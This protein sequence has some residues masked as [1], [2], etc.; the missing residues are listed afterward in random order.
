MVF[1]QLEDCVKLIIW[2]VYL[3]LFIFLLISG[4]SEPNSR[5]RVDSGYSVRPDSQSAGLVAS[6]SK[7]LDTF[8]GVPVCS[9]C[10]GVRLTTVCREE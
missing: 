4:N 3:K 6:R 7:M 5:G 9:S 10:L 2:H 8:L 1:L